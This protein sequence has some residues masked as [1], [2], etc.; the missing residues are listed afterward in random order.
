MSF[1]C[2]QL[3]GL[4]WAGAATSDKYGANKSYDENQVYMLMEMSL[5]RHREL[6]YEEND[7][8]TPSCM[9]E[10][11][12]SL[13]NL[14]A[15]ETKKEILWGLRAVTHR[16]LPIDIDERCKEHVQVLGDGKIIVDHVSEF[17]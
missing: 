16:D 9:A 1:T 5:I 17:E 15:P 4:A 7:A 2:E 13:N 11:D 14:L 8:L 10:V 6:D 3:D 12:A